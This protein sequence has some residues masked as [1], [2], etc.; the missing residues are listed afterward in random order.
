MRI[1]VRT[2]LEILSA[3]A[4][5]DSYAD[6]GDKRIPYKY[7]GATRLALAGLRRRLRAVQEDYTE[8]RNNLIMELSNGTGELPTVPTNGADREERAR[9]I[10]QHVA[11]AVREREMLAAEVELELEPLTAAALKLDD[12]P[13]PPG[14]LDMLG[15]ML[16]IPP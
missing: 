16:E 12:N 1:T 13:I 14:V 10:A 7:D 6:G 2:A 15:P 3:V 4:Q 9:A 8:A 5:L 11:L